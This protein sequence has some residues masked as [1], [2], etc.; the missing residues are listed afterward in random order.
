[1]YSCKTFQTLF[2]LYYASK[3][4]ALI[5]SFGV[6]CVEIEAQKST[7]D[8]LHTC[9]MH[10]FRWLDYAHFSNILL[11]LSNFLQ[12][13]RFCFSIQFH[14]IIWHYD[15]HPS[16]AN[17]LIYIKLFQWKF[18][19]CTVIKKNVNVVIRCRCEI[20]IFGIQTVK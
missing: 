12:V 18:Q 17:I 6:K 1:M 20:L 3:S 10:R 8:K 7:K 11:F 13:P 5:K 19:I 9:H 14:E 4:I 16:F 15:S 2:S